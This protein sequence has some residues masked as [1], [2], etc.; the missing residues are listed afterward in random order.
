LVVSV[1]THDF[2]GTLRPQGTTHDIGAYEY[3]GSTLS[4]PTSLTIVGD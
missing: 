1:V 4:S 2:V 3:K